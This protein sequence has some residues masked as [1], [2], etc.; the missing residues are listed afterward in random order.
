MDVLHETA[1][2][3]APHLGDARALA[4]RQGSSLSDQRRHGRAQ[5]EPRRAADLRALPGAAP[6]RAGDRGLTPRPSSRRRLQLPL[7]CLVGGQLSG[8]AT[9]SRGG[10][11]LR[12]AALQ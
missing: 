3:R 9:R 6:M 10:R 12:S 4:A 8:G 7:P 2:S 5:L 11:C 1:T